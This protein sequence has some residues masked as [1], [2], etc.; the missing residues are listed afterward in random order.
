MHANLTYCLIHIHTIYFINLDRTVDK[1]PKCGNSIHPGLFDTKHDLRICRAL[2]N[3]DFLLM[4]I[5][6]F[7]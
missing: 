5:S 2:E 1:I 3:K 6:T 4:Y 7:I